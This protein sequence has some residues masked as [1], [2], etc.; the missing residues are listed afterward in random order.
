VPEKKIDLVAGVYELDAPEGE[1]T[2]AV[3]VTET[4]GEV[5]LKTQRASR[6]EPSGRKVTGELWLTWNIYAFS[7]KALTPGISGEQNIRTFGLTSSARTSARRLFAWRV[8]AR[9][10]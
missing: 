5:V 4:L 1:T 3:K 8:S 10:T 2:V 9:R 6:G 7:S